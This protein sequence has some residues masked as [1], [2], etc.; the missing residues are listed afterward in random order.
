[1]E[2]ERMAKRHPAPL[3]KAEAIRGGLAELLRLEVRTLRSKFILL[4]QLEADI[5]RLEAASDRHVKA[6]VPKGAGSRA[7]RK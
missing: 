6:G 2:D 1:V 7:V 5:R 3:P 4:A